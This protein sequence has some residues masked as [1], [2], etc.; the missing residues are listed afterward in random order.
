MDRRPTKARCEWSNP[1]NARAE[2]PLAT[3]PN[4][5]TRIG[6]VSR[7][8]LVVACAVLLILWELIAWAGARF[9]IVQADLPRADALVVLSGS[10]TY[11]ERVEWAAHLFHEGRASRVILT[12]DDNRSGWSNQEE[13][14]PLF[15]E[16]AAE[17]LRAAGVPSIRI[18]ILPQ[19]V[20]STYTEALLLREYASANDLRSMLVVTSAYHSR[21]ALWTLRRV[22][23]G[24]EVE[25][26]LNAAPIG[27]QTP[28]SGLWWLSPKGWQNVAG[29]YLKFAYYTFRYV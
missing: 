8:R 1:I 22:F 2:I 4:L 18:E 26:G 28:K 16:R 23:H 20:S 3:L 13:R 24:T 6:I 12:N 25:I 14:N 17:Q 10:S 19:P 9:L 27:S 29:E 21:R 5:F 15:V 11:A 7:R